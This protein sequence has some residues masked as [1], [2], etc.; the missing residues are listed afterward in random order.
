MYVSHAN[1]QSLEGTVA[2]PTVLALNRYSRKL[3]ITNDSASNNLSFKFNLSEDYGTL[4]PT[5]SLSAYVRTNEVY[6]DGDGDYRV[7]AYG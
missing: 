6:L 1:F 4:L 5:E 2:A 7:W 3:V